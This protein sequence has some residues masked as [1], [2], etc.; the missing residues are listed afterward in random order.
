MEQA[1]GDA[2]ADKMRDL[3]DVKRADSMDE[4]PGETP[5]GRQRDK[6]K[7]QE[8]TEFADQVNEFEKPDLEEI[9]KTMQE[10]LDNTAQMTRLDGDDDHPGSETE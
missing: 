7:D 3:D 6:E 2:Q 4:T 10:L 5:D 9:D 8:K 1:K